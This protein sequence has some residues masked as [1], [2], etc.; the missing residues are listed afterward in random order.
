MPRALITGI[1]G[2]DGSYLADLLL[3]DGTDVVGLIRAEDRDGPNLAHLTGRVRLVEGDLLDPASLRAA[4]GDVEPDE[5]YH[6]A[7]PTFVPASWDDPTTTVAAIAGATSTILAAARE[8]DPAMRV[9]VAT[10]SEIFGDAGV[11]PQDEDSPKRPRSPYGVAKLA[12]HQLIALLRERHGQHVSAGITF[13]HESPRRPPHFVPR[14]I[15]RGAAAISLGLQDELR[16]GDLGAQRDWTD[17]RDVVRGAVLAL[18]HDVPGDY[19][20][21]SGVP[22]TV[23]DLVDAAFAHVGVDPA[24]RVVVDPE[25]VR[26]PEPTQLLGDPTRAREVLGWEPRIGFAQMI[27]EMVETDLAE[28]R[29]AG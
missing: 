16:L 10:S 8:T 29:A 3:E 18:R 17:A 5:L 25:F 7:A 28:L 23:K 15:T 21:A 4:V 22:R 24:G 1:A 11:S 19:V 6:L 2:Q 13:N 14:K 27:G 20:F 12:A 9:Y 26:P